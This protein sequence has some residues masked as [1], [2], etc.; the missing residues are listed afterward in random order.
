MAAGDVQHH[1]AG[2]V[3]PAGGVPV[4][5]AA[6]PAVGGPRLPDQRRLPG[7]DTDTVDLAVEFQ[8]DHALGNGGA[9]PEQHAVTGA[10]SLREAVHVLRPREVRG[11]V[12]RLL[13]GSLDH[14]V[15]QLA[16]HHGE[17][18]LGGEHHRVLGLGADRGDLG[19]RRQ[20][21]GLLLRRRQPERDAGAR[22]GRGEERDPDEV[23][24]REVVLLRH[25]V[26][27]VHDLV[28]HVGD[29]LDEGHARVGDVVVGPLGSALL[30]VALGVVDELLEAPVVEVRGGQGHQRSLP[31]CSSGAADPSGPSW[32]GI[33]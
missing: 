26:E 6:G 13:I 3:E 17:F 1:L 29:R 18:A 23:Q 2:A 22:G 19:T 7:V 15:R 21:D 25:P 33:T 10:R 14:E 16:G 5:V 24:E 12:D 20:H 27:P 4:D 8:D 30:D 31:R 28:R 11:A 32:E 9:E